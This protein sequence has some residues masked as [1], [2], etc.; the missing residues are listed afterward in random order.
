M[1]E[2]GV[3][4]FAVAGIHGGQAGLEGRGE[5]GEDF[6]GIG[7]FGV[8]G[9]RVFGVVSAEGEGVDIVLGELAVE[10]NHAWASRVVVI[11][12]LYFNSA[13]GKASVTVGG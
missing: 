6:E 8:A 10:R 5:I 4:R 3:I 11:G 12:R 1:S 13:T 9:R 2:H 7:I